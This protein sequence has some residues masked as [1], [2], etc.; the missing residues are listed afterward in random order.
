VFNT[1]SDKGRIIEPKK[2]IQRI[3]SNLEFSFTLHDLRRTFTTIAESLNLGTYTLKRLLNH[4]TQRDDVTAG[5]TI[6]TPEELRAPAQSIENRI[7]ELAELKT[8]EP[9]EG[10]NMDALLASLSDEERKSLFI[11]LLDRAQV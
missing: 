8:E 11:K 2:V 10:L 3:N 4:K 6:L 7:L 9:V 5:Y 1:N